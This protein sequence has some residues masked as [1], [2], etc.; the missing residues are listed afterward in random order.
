MDLE[1]SEWS[2]LGFPSVGVTLFLR[3]ILS[4]EMESESPP[5]MGCSSNS[6]GH[7]SGLRGR[8]DLGGR[9]LRDSLPSSLSP[10]LSLERR[11]LA[12]DCPVFCLCWDRLPLVIPE[13][14]LPLRLPVV[15]P[16]AM[17]TCFWVFVSEGV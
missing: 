8:G 9:D 16:G 7:T 10:P 14:L 4:G 3:L 15:S 1:W 6:Q 13:L 11:L 17:E 5:I 2:P 12:G